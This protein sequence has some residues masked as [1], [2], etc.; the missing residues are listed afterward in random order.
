[1]GKRKKRLKKQEE[2]LLKQARKHIHKAETEIGRKDT[3]KDYWLGEAERFMKRA[4]QR[5]EI[6][7]KLEGKKD[8]DDKNKPEENLQERMNYFK[9]KSDEKK[10]HKCKKCGKEIGR[11]NLY[12]HKCMCNECFFD[13]QDM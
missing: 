2:G 9:E 13:E 10:E 8:E 3:T 1:M 4:E 6:R 5:A 12:W 11:H 7:K